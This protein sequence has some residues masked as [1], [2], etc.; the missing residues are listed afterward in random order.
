MAIAIAIAIEIKIDD[1]Y[2]AKSKI[3]FND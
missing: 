2:L 3:M 1:S